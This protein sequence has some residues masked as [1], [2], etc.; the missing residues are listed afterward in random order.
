[1]RA[2]RNKRTGLSERYLCVIRVCK[3]GDG[4]NATA[5]KQAA[6]KDESE[7]E[8]KRAK[9]ERDTHNVRVRRASSEPKKTVRNEHACNIAVMCTDGGARSVSE[10]GREPTRA[11]LRASTHGC[12]G[13]CGALRC[14]ARRRRI[15]KVYARRIWCGMDLRRSLAGTDT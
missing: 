10:R 15:Y 13:E 9:N 14:V 12:C 6:R 5:A 1:M 3:S 2:K 4:R 7:S 11:T 8:R